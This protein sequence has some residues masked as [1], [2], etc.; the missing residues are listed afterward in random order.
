MTTTVHD[1]NLTKSGEPRCEMVVLSRS[2]WRDVPRCPHPAKITIDDMQLCGVHAR[3]VIDR[4][5]LSQ[6]SKFDGTAY[7][8]RDA[9]RLYQ[10]RRVDIGEFLLSSLDAG[11]NTAAAFESAREMRAAALVEIVEQIDEALASN[12]S[13]AYPLNDND[14]EVMTAHARRKRL[15][16]LIADLTSD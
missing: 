4:K 15:V 9:A 6:K 2:S 5:Q 7:A 1:D 12:A 8:S 10:R 13:S 14:N 11:S 16:E 3:S